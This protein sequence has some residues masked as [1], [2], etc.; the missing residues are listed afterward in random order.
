MDHKLSSEKDFKADMKINS[1]HPKAKINDRF[2][3][4]WP[5]ESLSLVH[6]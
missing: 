1:S 6:S 2:L 5:Q 3:Q 4:I